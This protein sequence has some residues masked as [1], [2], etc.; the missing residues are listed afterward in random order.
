MKRRGAGL[1][2]VLFSLFLAARANSQALTAAEVQSVLLETA[3]VFDTPYTIA[4]TNREGV[5][6]GVF[7]KTGAPPTTTSLIN[8]KFRLDGGGNEIL[9]PPEP[10]PDVAIALARTASF[11]SNNQAPLSSRTVRFISGIHFPP[12]IMNTPN[13]AL[14]GIENTNRGCFL[15]SDYLPGKEIPQPRRLNGDPGIGVV[16]GKRDVAN[17]VAYPNIVNSGGVPI[18]RGSTLIGGVGI[19]GLDALGNDDL[20]I[21][22][23]EFAAVQGIIQSQGGAILPVPNPL[24][25]PTE[26][27]IDGIRLPFVGENLEQR[28]NIIAGVRPANSPA[29]DPG[30]TGAF[31]VPAV[32]SPTPDAPTGWLVTPQSG[33]SLSA[34]EVETIILNAIRRAN[35]TRAAIRLSPGQPAKMVIA[36]GDLDGKI[37]GL[38]RMPD[39]TIFSIDVAATKSRNAVYFSSA[40][41]DP[42]DLPGVPPGTAVTARTISFAAQPLFPAGIGK[43]PL[44]PPT[45]AD[46]AREGPFFQS[47]F[48]PDVFNPCTQ[49]R[50]PVNPNQSGIVFFPGSTPLYK[51]GVLV[52]GL[53]VSGDGVEQDDYVTDAGWRGFEAPEEIRADRIFIDSVRLPYFKFPRNPEEGVIRDT[54]LPQ[55]LYANFNSG[56]PATIDIELVAGPEIDLQATA[57]SLEVLVEGAV[58]TLIPEPAGALAAGQV[59]VGIPFF[60]FITLRFPAGV[61]AASNIQVNL[62]PT[63]VQG[64]STDACLFLGIPPV[65]EPDCIAIT[66]FTKGGKAEVTPDFNRDKVINALDLLMLKEGYRGSGK[67]SDYDLDG[68]NSLDGNDLFDFGK[69]WMQK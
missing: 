30:A 13:A 64:R 32:G 44:F 69:G 55:I 56:P 9:S 27:F 41:V 59:G 28:S 24:P 43:Q 15:S 61:T 29:P 53:G 2:L 16:T 12:G 17:S 62:D 3:K 6:L 5:V 37:L 45:P 63:D 40:A 67:A 54:S 50:Q 57:D 22:V 21:R 68:D 8:F 1:F 39:A 66:T 38:Y 26:V 65:G 14:Y 4:V 60:N 10:T 36:V 11:F 58:Q 23:A 49:G 34:D 47:L 35:K 19:A 20:A 33:A 18:F 25:P 51:N 7:E 52:G 48:V 31:L 42:A 46:K